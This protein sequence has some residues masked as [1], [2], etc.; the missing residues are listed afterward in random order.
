M[1]LKRLAE[2]SGLADE[3]IESFD[4]KP[5]SRLLLNPNRFL[6]GSDGYP[7]AQQIHTAEIDLV[8][9]LT[10]EGPCVI[11]GRC[12]DSILAEHPGLVRLFVSA[13]MEDRVARVMRRNGLD[14]EQAR[15]RIARTDKERASYY[16]YFTD[17]KWG[18]A[19]NYD[20]CIN[21]A[22]ASIDGTVDVIAR[23][24]ESRQASQ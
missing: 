23:F 9:S 24:L 17:Q 22:M 20:L 6:S 14:E 11:V 15:A 13:P 12:V 21:S 2:R 10:T 18:L 4:E 7:L 8:R 16:R 1:L 5:F 3:V 19:S